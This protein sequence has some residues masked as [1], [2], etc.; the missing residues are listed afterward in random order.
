MRRTHSLI[1]AALSGM[2][3]VS[4]CSESGNEASKGDAASSR[5]VGTGG[6][7][8]D[9]KDFTHTLPIA[10]YEYS[11]TQE[12]LIARAKDGL[13]RACMQRFDLGYRPADVDMPETPTPSDRRYGISDPRE[14]ERYG[15]HL[16]PSPRIVPV[17][18]SD[19][20][21]PV[22][23]GTVSTYDGKEVPKGG[24]RAEAVRTWEK[25]RPATEA[26]DVAR[27]IAVNGFRKSLS[28]PS[29]LKVTKQWASCMK[30]EGF[31][32]PSPLAPPHDFDLDTPSAPD[33]ERKVAVA[34]LS[35][36]AK[37]NLLR[38]WSSAESRIQRADI[39]AS[40]GRLDQLSMEHGEVAEFAR[41][42]G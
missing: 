28:D 41:S 24:C 31:S 34:D 27:E 35:C 11:S 32:Y 21:H 33:E 29:V 20:S 14:A 16:A 19:P 6:H 36:K 30:G 7:P 15:Y 4:A 18:S 39:E 3:L 38:V 40:K 12:R 25:R 2:L 37:T 26:A 5:Q 17:P 9:T 22:L 10:K 8:G 42:I 23:Y 1:G 13:T